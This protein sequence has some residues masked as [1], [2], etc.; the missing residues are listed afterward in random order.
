MSE[1]TIEGDET[2]RWDVLASAPSEQMAPAAVHNPAST[3]GAVAEPKEHPEGTLDCDGCNGSGTYYGAGRVENGKF[4]GFS[5]TCFRCQG[6]G[7]QTES[8]V[9]RNRYY[10]NRVRRFTV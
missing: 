2:M 7:H 9:K 8:D 5:G 10:D 4:I 3:V 1:W 6:K